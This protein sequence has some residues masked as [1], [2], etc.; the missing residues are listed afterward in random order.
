MNEGVTLNEVMNDGKSIHLYFNGL[1]GLYVSYG[2]SAF[3][4]SKQT[5]VS[6]SYSQEMQ[7]PVAVINVGHFNLL[8]QQ[9]EVSKVVNNYCCLRPTVE[10]DE[11]EYADWVGR[12][13]KEK[14][15]D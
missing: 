13:R 1:V 6:P 10:Y 14:G 7:M 4:L 12:I 15:I 11:N 8:K 9:L 3:L 2:I 5:E